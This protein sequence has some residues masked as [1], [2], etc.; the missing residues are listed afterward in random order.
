MYGV[1]GMLGGFFSAIFLKI[2]TDSN[3]SLYSTNAAQYSL[4]SFSGALIATSSSVGIAIA[5]GLVVGL[6]LRAV[7]FDVKSDL[8]HD[9]AFWV[10][11]DDCISSY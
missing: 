10:I 4:Y 8:Y 7:S 5:A 6:V 9:R 1:Q 3:T 11:E 2:A